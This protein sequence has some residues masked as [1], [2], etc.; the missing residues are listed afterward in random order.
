MVLRLP[1]ILLTLL[2]GFTGHLTQHGA[3]AQE[4]S[5]TIAAAASMSDALEAIRPAYSAH[6]P[7]KLVYSYGATASLAQQIRH[8]APFDLLIS[9]DV[10]TVKKLAEEGSILSD[11]VRIY[12]RGRLVL[13]TEESSNVPL[14]TLE[15]I[16]RP[17]IERIAIAQPALAP[18]GRAAQEALQAAGLWDRIRDKLI[19]AENVNQ[20]QQY[21]ATRNTDVAFIP[22][23][24]AHRT[25]GR[26]IL[27]DER[28]HKPIDHA[29]GIV[30]TSAHR[31]EARIFAEFLLSEQGRV[32]LAKFGYTF[33]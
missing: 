22:L 3:S 18:Y 2:F 10:G 1:T 5:L 24:L 33:P 7:I 4:K 14:N 31:D 28:L 32:I 13:W 30:R 21:A 11:S 17:E 26:F 27:V 19:Y 25:R 9:A 29:L 15:D 23:A 16:L 8:G 20:A 12:A 6:H